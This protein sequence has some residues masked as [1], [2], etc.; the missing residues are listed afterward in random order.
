V[1]VFVRSPVKELFSLVER[2]LPVVEQG[3][4]LLLRFVAAVSGFGAPHQGAVPRVQGLRAALRSVVGR[5]GGVLLLLQLCL[6][7]IAELAQPRQ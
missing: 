3:F 7:F 6:A 1:P 5:A 4:P 2:C